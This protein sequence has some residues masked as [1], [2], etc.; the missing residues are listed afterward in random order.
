M[1]YSTDP[2]PFGTV[3][4][5]LARSLRAQ[6]NR[7][8]ILASTGAVPDDRPEPADCFDDHVNLLRGRPFL[9]RRRKWLTDYD[10]AEGIVRRSLWNSKE[11]FVVVMLAAAACPCSPAELAPL[12]PDEFLQQIRALAESPTDLANYLVGYKQKVFA[13]AEYW[14]DVLK[15][16]SLWSRFFNP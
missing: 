3:T 8:V 2:T 5:S 1:C 10:S 9:M 16:A 4:Y 14:E 12:I 13:E 11:Q 15:G 6:A 7:Y